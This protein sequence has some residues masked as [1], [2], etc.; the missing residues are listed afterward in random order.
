[1]VREKLKAKG[2]KRSKRDVTKII[3]ETRKHAKENAKYLKGFDSLKV[4]R[5]IRNEHA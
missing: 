5:E 4:L 3:A 1:M 2:N